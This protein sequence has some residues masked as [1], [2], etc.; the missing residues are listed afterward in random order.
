LSATLSDIARETGTSISTVSRVLSGGA[1]AQRI[2]QSTR[3]RVLAAARRLGYR[4][5]LLARSLRTRRSHTIA[6]LVSDIA[7]PWFGQIASL[8]ERSLHQHGYSLML[9][10]SG[11][12]AQ[13]EM[14]YLQLLPRKGIDG[15][16]IV[17]VLRT[18]K[19]LAELVPSDL[20]VVVLDRP[21]PGVGHS[22]STDEQQSAGALC[23]VLARAG[24]RSVAL[25]AGPAH[26]I[27]HRQRAEL[28]ANCFQVTQKIQGPAQKET[29][30][31]AII[32]L[33]SRP[34]AIVCTNNFLGQGLLEAIDQIDSPPIVGCFDE[35]PMMHLL[36][37]P[38]V[39][40]V[41]DLAM[42]AEGCVRQLLPQLER[43]AGVAASADASMLLQAR[44]VTNR[45]FQTRP[46]SLPD[47]AAQASLS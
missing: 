8:I 1:S 7:N 16:I 2:S 15:L 24:V 22:V 41:Q 29:G 43:S 33:A 27:T 12:D 6:L 9:C 31:R 5:N 3:N 47:E 44:I 32:Q 14:Q 40:S 18:R 11:E 19:A 45:A 34:D 20:P 37:L 39:C 13:Q 30:R 21:I 35:I 25:V 23:D 4:P 38:I 17:P 42:L 28:V 10:N 36:P 46:L 26:I